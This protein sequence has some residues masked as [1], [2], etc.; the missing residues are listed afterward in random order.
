VALIERQF[1]KAGIWALVAAFFSAI[2]IIHAYELTPG[3]VTSRFGW[4]AAPEFIW[5]YV[6]LAFLFFLVAALARKVG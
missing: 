2:G 1:V 3:G 4:F 5:A 6:L